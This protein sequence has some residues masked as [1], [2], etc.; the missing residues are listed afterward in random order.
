M[1]VSSR[2]TPAPPAAPAAEVARPAMLGRRSPLDLGRERIVGGGA[3]GDAE[4][5]A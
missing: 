1:V 3:H 5:R 4:P 2:K